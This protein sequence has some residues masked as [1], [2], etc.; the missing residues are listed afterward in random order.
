[1]T[2]VKCIYPDHVTEGHADFERLKYI[3]D[4]CKTHTIKPGYALEIWKD[5][6]LLR[7]FEGEPIESETNNSL[8]R[9][10]SD[11]SIS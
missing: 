8:H 6:H 3:V 1:M 4:K 11:C 10:T 2:L 7:R 9:E 5:G